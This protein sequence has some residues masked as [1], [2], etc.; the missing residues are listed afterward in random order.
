M[1]STEIIVPRCYVT[2][3]FE[4]SFISWLFSIFAAFFV[5]V[6]LY[7]NFQVTGVVALGLLFSLRLI[8]ARIPSFAGLP[9]IPGFLIVIESSAETVSKSN[10]LFVVRLV[11]LV[12]K[13][14]SVVHFCLLES[15]VSCCL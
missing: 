2:F 15:G 4:L 3:E 8:S 7:L 5:V 14:V 6:E 9:I 11:R 12:L 13:S 10:F 1:I